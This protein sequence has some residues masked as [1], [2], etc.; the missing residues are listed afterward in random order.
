M[1]YNYVGPIYIELGDGFNLKDI[2]F[3]VIEHIY[4]IQV[5]EKAADYIIQY[6][7]VYGECEKHSDTLTIRIFNEENRK[8]FEV[9]FQNLIKTFQ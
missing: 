9:L 8:E 1:K 6:C 3:Q 5:V 2:N 4:I 7:G